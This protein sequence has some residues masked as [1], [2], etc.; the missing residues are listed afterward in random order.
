MRVN[1]QL[2]V[3]LI[4]DDMKRKHKPIL[5]R[6]QNRL[7]NIYMLALIAI[8]L[9]V[10]DWLTTTQHN[11]WYFIASVLVSLVIVLGVRRYSTRHR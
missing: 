7:L 3:R 10:G 2:S 1:K 4:S 5:Q 8:A 6:P 9:A 11:P